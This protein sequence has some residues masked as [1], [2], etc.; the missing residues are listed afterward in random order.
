[1][2][3]ESQGVVGV[4]LVMQI[5]VSAAATPAQVLLDKYV[6]AAKAEPGY[7][8]PSVERGRALFFASHAGGK[9]DTPGCTSCHTKD[10]TGPG[11]TRRNRS[12]RWRLRSYRPATRTRRTSKNGS[13]AIAKTCSAGSAAPPKRPTCSHFC[14]AYKDPT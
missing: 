11:Q 8:G 12:S 4:F 14:S 13:S 5:L 9:T 6:A 3:V 1:M 2:I 7:F 10:L